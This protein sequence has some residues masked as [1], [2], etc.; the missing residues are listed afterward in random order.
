MA[1]IRGHT[2]VF[3]PQRAVV[4]DLTGD[5]RA[6]VAMLRECLSASMAD[7][8]KHEAG[9][10][11]YHLEAG[12]TLREIADLPGRPFVPEAGLVHIGRF[13]ASE[14]GQSM[15][16]RWD[17]SAFVSAGLDGY[18]GIKAF[19][20]KPAAMGLR[21]Q[22]LSPRE[23]L[24]LGF[25]G[26]RAEMADG[27]RIWSL[28]E[29]WGEW[30]KLGGRAHYLAPLTCRRNESGNTPGSANLLVL[31]YDPAEGWRVADHIPIDTDDWQGPFVRGDCLTIRVP[32][33]P[34]N[35]YITLYYVW[36]GDSFLHRRCAV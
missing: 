16:L 22:G 21:C 8:E 34:F 2:V 10:G 9:Y 4:A 24:R 15:V 30:A 33:D 5:G 13:A 36:Q 32:D 11:V 29:R 35:D 27:D 18:P 1:K 20:L 23:E 25:A 26:D 6:E 14:P 17:G 7:L 31:R 28:S 3:T 19:D 12:G